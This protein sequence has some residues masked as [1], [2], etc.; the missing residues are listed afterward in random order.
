MRVYPGLDKKK[1]KPECI[2]SLKKIE[3]KNGGEKRDENNDGIRF[4][5]RNQENLFYY[6][7]CVFRSSFHSD[8]F[9]HIFLSIVRWLGESWW[10][11][12]HPEWVL[13]VVVYSTK[14]S[15]EAANGEK[16][17]PHSALG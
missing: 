2:K 11:C 17:R 13:H 5:S 16:E 8:F 3:Q 6:C 7:Y 9:A 12:V 10:S 1:T 4:R 14:I 15:T